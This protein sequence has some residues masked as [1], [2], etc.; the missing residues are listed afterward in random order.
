MFN[1]HDPYNWEKSMT[2]KNDFLF[3]NFR[4][5]PNVYLQSNYYKSE[6]STNRQIMNDERKWKMKK[7]LEGTLH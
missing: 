3:T 2:P 7:I 5:Y 1:F 6:F 4:K